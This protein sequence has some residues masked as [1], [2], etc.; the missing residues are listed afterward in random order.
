MGIGSVIRS[1]F[2]VLS[3]HRR[4]MYRCGNIMIVRAHGSGTNLDAATIYRWAKVVP[5][6]F[7]HRAAPLRGRSISRIFENL[8]SA[9]SSHHYAPLIHWRHQFEF[10]AR[11][12]PR[13]HH[14]SFAYVLGSTTVATLP[15]VNV[16][17]K[18]VRSNSWSFNC[19]SNIALISA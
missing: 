12:T 17:D 15:L 2:F 9:T 19:V 5:L 7:S 1:H 11:Y 16:C 14:C 4:T 18:N 6:A 10:M 3:Q 8:S 13:F